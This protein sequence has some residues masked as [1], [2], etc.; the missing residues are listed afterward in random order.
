MVVRV[1]NK[2]KDEKLS[3]FKG[4]IYHLKYHKR[5]LMNSFLP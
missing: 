1:S 3:Y 5:L 4:L 2:V